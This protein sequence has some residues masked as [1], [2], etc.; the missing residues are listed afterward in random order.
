METVSGLEPICR[1]KNFLE[2][3]RTLWDLGRVETE[4]RE[5]RPHKQTH[6]QPRPEHQELEQEMEADDEEEAAPDHEEQT[7]SCPGILQEEAHQSP[8]THQGDR[9]GLHTGPRLRRNQ[10]HH[11]EQNGGQ[12]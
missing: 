2:R 4:V 5:K 6:I 12:V 9:R 8:G 7:G 1:V 10:S 3:V 11:V